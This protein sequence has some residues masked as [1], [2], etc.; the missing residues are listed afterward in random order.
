MT[1]DTKEIIEGKRLITNDKE[2][3]EMM[4]QISQ[5]VSKEKEM[6][7]DSDDKVVMALNDMRIKVLKNHQDAHD[8]TKL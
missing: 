6:R 7:R 2:M 3:S 4:K 1:R 5:D 8:I